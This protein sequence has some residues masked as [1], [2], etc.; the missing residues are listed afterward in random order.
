MM[1][2]AYGIP[3]L[4]DQMPTHHDYPYE[5]CF[6]PFTTTI[7]LKNIVFIVEQE[8]IE[9]SIIQGPLWALMNDMPLYCPN[10]S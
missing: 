9:P 3:A 6:D 7:G 8:G 4:F 10:A 2:F 5:T 1:V